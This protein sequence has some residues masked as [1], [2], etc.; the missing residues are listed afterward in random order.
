MKKAIL[1]SSLLLLNGCFMYQN[2]D[3]ALRGTC[4]DEDS[5]VMTP[6][7]IA[8][9]EKRNEQHMKELAAYE[10]AEKEAQ[11]KAIAKIKEICSHYNKRGTANYAICCSARENLFESIVYNY[12]GKNIGYA[13]AYDVMIKNIKY[14]EGRCEK[15]GLKRGTSEFYKC[16]NELEY[17]REMAKLKS[18]EREANRP[19]VINDNS[20]SHCRST[21]IGSDTYTD[22]Y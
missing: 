13:K 6:E 5:F 11:G 20:P 18:Q 12:N 4:E 16:F 2:F 9:Q 3:C 7:E 14:Y 1:F 22:C 15:Y 10:K 19:I 8:A 17:S 21:R